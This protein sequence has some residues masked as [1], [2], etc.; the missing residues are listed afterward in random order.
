MSE[1]KNTRRVTDLCGRAFV[2]SFVI[3]FVLSLTNQLISRSARNIGL[4][5]AVPVLIGFPPDRIGILTYDR[6]A[7][8]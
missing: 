2:R 4:P 5:G 1:R 7:A 8:A 6:V 3:F